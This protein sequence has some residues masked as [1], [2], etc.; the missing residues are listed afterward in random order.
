MDKL[1]VTTQSH[2]EFID[3]TQEVNGILEKREIKEGICY[4]FVPH[5]TAAVTINENADPSVR[6]DIVNELNRLVPWN[7]HYTHMEGN[8]A[9]HIKAS[10]VGSSVSIPISGG[11]LA[12][13]TWQ[14]IYFCEFDGPR[15]REVFVQIIKRE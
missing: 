6:K 4:V 3:I 1:H 7:G 15:R 10:L 14:G 5:T 13:G 11:K 8:A 12:L 2:A 9:A